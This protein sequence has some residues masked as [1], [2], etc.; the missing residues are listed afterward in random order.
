MNM[1]A[2][3][4]DAQPEAG[5]TG[6][7]RDWVGSIDTSSAPE[8]A[9]AAFE[10]YPEERR[11]VPRLVAG[12]L[13]LLAL[14]WTG[15]A[16]WTIL[17]RAEPATIPSL[18]QWI[19]FISP[20]LI[21]LGIAWL[22]LG[23][24]PRRE[25]ERF[26][27]AV[28]AMRNESTALEAVLAVVATR[29]E[30][31]H[32]RL[33]GEAEKLMR[34]GDDAQDRLGRVAHYLSRESA[35]LDKRSEALESAAEAARVDIGVL[36]QDLPRAEEHARSLSEAMK[37]AGLTAHNQTGA[38]E[39]QLSALVAR[40]RE[41]DEVVGG[42]AQ[43]LA[44][45]LARVESTTAAAATRMDEAAASMT[46]AV[47]DTM[48]R[49]AEAVDA[50]RSGLQA[51][52]AAMLAMI[53]QSRAALD[54]AGEDAGR[55]LAQRLETISGKIEGLAGHL[56]A[57]DAASHALVTGLAK[58]LSELDQKFVQLGQSGTGNAEL[59]G[60]SIEAVRT[61]VGEL[62]A[63][64]TGSQDRAASLIGRA[65][66][67]AEAL[68]GVTAQL[69]GGVPE[70]LS[71]VQEQA[72]RAE[73]T[74]AAIAP[75]VTQIEASSGKAAESMAAAEASVARQRETLDETARTVTTGLMAN[76]ADLET[77]F[78]GVHE[79]G[80]ARARDL[81]RALAEVGGA[82]S[83]LADSLGGGET[84]AADLSARA[85]TIRNSLA[86]I[87][88][89][90]E[91]DLPAGLTA[92]EQQTERTRA[93]AMD[94]APQVQAIQ[95]AAGEAAAR[96]T[97]AEASV[98][99]QQ[100]ALE[101]AART[102]AADLLARL[103]DVEQKFAAVRESG[104]ARAQELND[105]LTGVSAAVSELAESLEGGE[106]RAADLSGRAETI[107]HN[108]AGIH[109]ALQTELPAGLTGIEQ[110]AERTRALALDIAPHVQA[111]HSA[112]GDAAARLAEAEA[113]VGRQH[114]ALES[115]ARSVAA[116]LIG[117]LTEVEQ[118]F[119]AVREQGGTRTAE[120]GTALNAVRDSVAEL[121]QSLTGGEARAAALSGRATEIQE[122]LAGIASA[123]DERLPALLE[124]LD[125]QAQ[126]TGAAAGEIAP[127]IETLHSLA[128]ST[129]ARLEQADGIV[130]RQREALD[131]LL[132]R[133]DE[134]VGSAEAQL[135]AL[136]GA[137]AE[138][139]E[140]A[141]RMIQTSGPELIEALLRVRETAT[142]AAERARE[143][144]SAVIPQ[145]AAALAD[146]SREA[147]ENAIGPAVERQLE[148]LGAI[149]ERAVET[150]RKASE[151]L[152]RQMLT[153]GEAAAAVE[154]RID[155]ERRER[156]ASESDQFSRR[157]A[158]LIESLNSTA[159]DVT[160]ILSNEVTD[161][162]WASYLK[163][164]RGVFT[165]RAVRLIDNSEAREIVQHYENEPEF[166][167]Q[168]NRYI[169]DF[170]AMLRR[171][172][173]DRDSSA[174]GVTVLSSDMGKLYVALAQAIERLR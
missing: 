57:Q 163:G 117:Q 64:L 29:L 84:R 69:S 125:Q 93:I 110:Q 36:L 53:E 61:R 119:A 102:V 105:A 141:G 8:G 133:L 47:D 134:G 150:A 148:E 20:P 62:A 78:A 138:A 39:G 43:R 168:V 108:L 54:R 67:M 18:L 22:I 158:L 48:A 70:A 153:I 32:A 15:V 80:G 144:I 41:A 167:E 145:S 113:S 23:H 126:R 95:A 164:D 24:T 12:L 143:A 109:D 159:I 131:A 106:A 26:R 114:A 5:I 85:E 103:A 155:Q 16:V 58:E 97:E 33:T 81:G 121:A 101:G 173:A 135:R 122:S 75:H 116:D 88:T 9:V 30:E 87:H 83:E 50:A 31:N 118:R 120:L 151:R 128:E 49:A 104:G 63:D 46:A 127:R 171:I 86:G 7:T 137:V 25:T 66:E 147:V 34:L 14:A 4:A 73:R 172:L 28:A 44:S 99:R 19:T 152:T 52:G 13:I 166:R 60:T 140:A 90:L 3:R 42:A 35:N 129:A 10:E 111:L 91:T 112:A 2:Q 68:S 77:R 56:A 169:H 157:V 142:Q 37:E 174:L 139:D 59:L 21:L 162:A 161:S 51:Q 149:A 89:A 45:H 79:T 98:G 92:I 96:L 165:R 76:L 6:T 94:I 123:L 136:G 100:A 72:E 115:A 38:L 11:T 1:G 71:R 55:N 17:Q 74:A 170:E 154:A 156:E 160:K 124:R 65:H 107:R 82:I 146:A 132:A 40:G 27:R 130:E